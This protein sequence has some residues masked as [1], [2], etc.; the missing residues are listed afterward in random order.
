MIEV[1]LIGFILPRALELTVTAI[2]MVPGKMDQFDN[3]WGAKSD[4][5]PRFDWL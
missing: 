2:E 3:L 4:I 5:V 1:S